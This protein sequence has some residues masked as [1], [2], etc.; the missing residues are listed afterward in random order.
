MDQVT[1]GKKTW[2]IGV[3]FHKTGT[4]SL[5]KALEIHGFRVK[6]VTPEA[7]IPILKGNYEK[8][9]KMIEGFD[10]LEDTPWFM[11]Y[12]E[13]DKQFPGSKFIL[14]IREAEGWYDSIC[15]HS[16]NIRTAQR[17][18]IYGRGNGNPAANKENTLKVYKD[19]NEQVL[20]YF[21]DRPED[22][23]VMDLTIGDGWEKLCGFLNLEI[24]GI[25][26]PH[27]NKKK[28]N[29]PDS[30][31][32]YRFRQMRRRFK[33]SIKIIYIQMLGLNGD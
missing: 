11:I 17:E 30:V 9:Y 5:G 20:E 32:R 25:P 28:K 26:F 16:D 6:S 19:H 21:K 10:V 24:P 8:V 7:L 15:R 23:L 12:R 1:E 13:L 33:N 22:L 18:W 2:I 31:L 29:G 4:T 3:G 27:K 14:T